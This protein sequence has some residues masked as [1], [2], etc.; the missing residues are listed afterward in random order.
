MI[1]LFPG[2]DMWISWRVYKKVLSSSFSCHIFKSTRLADAGGG[3]G[4]LKRPGRGVARNRRNG[5]SVAP[6][7]HPWISLMALHS[8]PL[9]LISV[10]TSYDMTW[11]HIA[12]SYRHVVILMMLSHIM[13]YQIIS[14]HVISYHHAWQ[15]IISWVGDCVKVPLWI[16]SKN[17]VSSEE[18]RVFLQTI[19]R[20][21]LQCY[22]TQIIQTDIGSAVSTRS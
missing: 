16:L 3:L 4:T 14:Y 17:R 2:W 5:N 9:K 11:T 20:T 1:F 21:M 19:E 18:V 10:I 6:L 7:L 22:W 12:L 13:S 8:S 15:H